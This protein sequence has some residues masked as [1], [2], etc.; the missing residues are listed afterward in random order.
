MKVVM[1]GWRVTAKKRLFCPTPRG[2]V[3]G[4]QLSESGMVGAVRSVGKQKERGCVCKNR[5][6]KT[7]TNV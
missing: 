5:S 3:F 2:E 7:G 6:K 1:M 4:C